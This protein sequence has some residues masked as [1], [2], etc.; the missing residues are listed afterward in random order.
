MVINIKPL[1]V[2]NCWQ[3]KRFKTSEYKNYEQLLFWQ[4]PDINIDFNKLHIKITF[5]FSSIKSDID[6]PVKPF[7]DILQK[8]YKFD[9]SIIYKLELTKVKVKKE[10]EYIDFEILEY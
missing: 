4:L 6:N 5:G 2:N 9:D 10:N 1:S 3:G 8:R 7:L